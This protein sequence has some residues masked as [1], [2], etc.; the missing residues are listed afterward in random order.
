[1]NAL[2]KLRRTG[3]VRGHD[4]MMWLLWS[5]RRLA[6]AG[7]AVL[8]VGSMALSMAAAG[9]L[10][11][12][13][14]E[15]QAAQATQAQAQEESGAVAATSP[16]DVARAWTQLWLDPAPD[17]ADWS[18]SLVGLSSAKQTQFLLSVDR[19]VIAPATVVD[20][21]LLTADE[22]DATVRVDLDDDTSM[23]LLL[24][25][26]VRGDWR[27]DGIAEVADP[28]ATAVGE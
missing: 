21:T 12:F 2:R 17:K 10:N 14:T 5:P 1:M 25:R 19:T 18:A 7:L 16:E 8:V 24:I 22:E 23:D 26:G 6:G 3:R 15:Q 11:A 4:A 28:T 20:A 13:L 27:V 9:T